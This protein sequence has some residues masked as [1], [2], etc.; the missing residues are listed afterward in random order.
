MTSRNLPTIQVSGFPDSQ[1]IATEWRALVKKN[2][3]DA[4][5][6]LYEEAQSKYNPT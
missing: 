5:E 3:G 4:V 6:K 2:L 1:R